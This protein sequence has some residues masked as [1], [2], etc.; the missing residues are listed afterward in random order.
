MSGTARIACYKPKS[1][2]G[3]LTNKLGYAYLCIARALDAQGKHDEARAAARTAAEHF[4]S[5]PGPDHPDTRSAR[6]QAASIPG[7][8]RSPNLNL[9]LF[10]LA[11][12]LSQ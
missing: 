3:T 6:Q 5:A 12:R 10:P 2:P 11:F 7:S 4:Q 1:N 8:S 9:S